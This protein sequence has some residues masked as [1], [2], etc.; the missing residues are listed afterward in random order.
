MKLLTYVKNK[1]LIN[2]VKVLYRYKI[3][4]LF[5]KLLLPI[6][7]NKP[8]KDTIVIE[9][10]NDFDSN[11][12]AFYD[13]LIKNG[14]NKKYRLV[15]LLKNPCP[16]Q[17]PDNVVWYRL[18]KPSI[19]KT[20][21]ILSA[22]YLVTCNN[23]LGS[24]VKNQKSYYLTHGPLALKNV[25]GNAVLPS[26]LSYL[27]TPS[28]FTRPILR[29]MLLP[30]KTTA[31][32]III[33]YPSHDILYSEEFG[34]LEK[35]T[36]QKYRK[37]VLWMPTFRTLKNSDRVDSE[38]EMPM[39]IPVI[40]NET[41]YNILNEALKRL[42]MFLIIKIHPMQRLEDIKVRTMS[43]IFVLDGESVKTLQVDNYRLMRDVDAL[44][45]DYSSA[46]TDFMHT[47][48]PL[49]YTM[50]DLNEYKIGFIVDDV[51]SLMPGQKIN[52][53]QDMITFCE[54]LSCGRDDYKEERNQVFQLLF[55]YHDGNSCERLARHMGIDK[56]KG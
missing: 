54:D 49:G 52:N 15:W 13:Y 23:A 41:E 45:T 33:G 37:T 38:Y 30:E 16:N 20:Y 31:E 5:Q 29:D 17:L 6:V 24:F 11:G 21:D 36:K 12:G 32:Q 2:M 9:S 44:I 7:K 4:V 14:Y 47:N 53:L 51:E 55:Q 40:R 34:D 26:T 48:R 10:H 18:F 8:L 19:R 3:D 56:L 35:I 50:D 1:G 25:K 43:N 27:L 22:K 46:G 42:D 39:G 28:E